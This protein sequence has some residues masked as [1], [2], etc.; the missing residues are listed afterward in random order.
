M[1]LQG[2]EEEPLEASSLRD[3]DYVAVRR[4]TRILERGIDA[5]QTVD[6]LINRCGSLVNLRAAIMR[7]RKPRRS[8]RF[9]RCD[10]W[11]AD[12]IQSGL[13]VRTWCWFSP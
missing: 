10:Y 6:A 7:Y 8:F 11:Q 3:G 2:A 12:A 13:L 5:K 1:H 4:F 9:F